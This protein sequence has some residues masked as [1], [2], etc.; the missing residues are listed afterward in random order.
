MPLIGTPHEIDFTGIC[1][2]PFLEDI[3]EAP[4]RIDRNC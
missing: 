2:S 3:E 1:H 4:Y